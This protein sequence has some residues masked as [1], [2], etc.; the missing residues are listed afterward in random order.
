[1]RIL[2]LILA[3]FV[4]S[5]SAIAKYKDC[6]VL[7]FTN[8]GELVIPVEAE[9]KFLLN[10]NT[11]TVMTKQY[12]LSNIRKYTFEDSDILNVKKNESK[13]Y[14]YS[15]DGNKILVKPQSCDT[16][17]RLFTASGLQFPLDT[18]KQDVIYI[19]LSDY[20][21]NILFLQIGNETIKIMRK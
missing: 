2:F 14:S 19:D 18:S 20:V 1:M 5:C 21:E 17:V 13:G 15:I 7:K 8:S 9:P 3:T 12:L 10:G 4:L 16:R 11:I 6:I